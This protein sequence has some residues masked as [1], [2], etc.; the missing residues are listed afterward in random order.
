VLIAYWSAKG[1]SGTTVLASGHA[2]AAAASG[3]ALLVDLAGDAPV[4]LGCPGSDAGVA[5]W[6]A[7]GARV[8]ADALDRIARSVSPNL[9]LLTRGEGELEPGRAEVLAGLLATSPG[10]VVVDCGTRPGPVGRAVAR[11]ADRS[12]L[13]T[14]AC[15]LAVRGQMSHDLAPTGIAL[16]KEPHRCLGP[17][18][19]S[20]ALG[21]PVVTTV[22]FDPGISRAVDA[23]LLRARLPR[24]FQRLAGAGPRRRPGVRS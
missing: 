20:A 21:A 2:L 13:V 24:P 3:P 5:Q 8:P 10:T 17:G 15:Y 18:E 7:A 23:G 1:G 19:L 16:V 11:A 22:P 14:R 9:R 6:L 4:A 12:I